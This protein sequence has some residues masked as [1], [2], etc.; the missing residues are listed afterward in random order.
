MK[1]IFFTA[2]ALLT[3]TVI[4]ACSKQTASDQQIKNYILAHPEVLVES[5][6]KYQQQESQADN[7]KAEAEIGKQSDAIFKNPNSPIIGNPNGKSVIVEF[8][9]YNCHYCKGILPDLKKVVAE[10]K[11]VKVIFKELPILGP[12]SATTALAALAVHDFAPDKYFA[13]HTALMEHAGPAD[14]NSIAA[15]AQKA[16]IDPAVLEKKIGDKKYEKILSDNVNLAHALSIT[17]TPTFIINGKVVRGAIR[18]ENMKTALAGK[19]Q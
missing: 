4:S 11:D 9:D 5:L 15:A 19:A 6:T 14:D 13:F 10:N 12:T 17:G 16:G 2:A 18:Y 8:F 1:K 7:K 3:L